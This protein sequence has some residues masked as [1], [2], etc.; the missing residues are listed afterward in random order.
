MSASATTMRIER[1]MDWGKTLPRQGPWRDR[2][3]P[4]GRVVAIPRVWWAARVITLGIPPKEDLP[5][6]DLCFDSYQNAKPT[7]EVV[8]LRGENSTLRRKPKFPGVGNLIRF[9]RERVLA[10]DRRFLRLEVGPFQPGI[11]EIF[12]LV[13]VGPVVHA[14][15]PLTFAVRRNAKHG[16]FNS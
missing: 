3:A 14:R 5:A 15:H 1:T 12:P 13:R 11:H 9:H 7:C 6:N 10:S 16:V 8:E 4:Y 2:P